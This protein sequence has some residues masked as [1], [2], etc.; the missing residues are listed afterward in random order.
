MLQAAVPPS[1]QDNSF[2]EGDFQ[3][4][5]EIYSVSQNTFDKMS[6]KEKKAI[7]RESHL[8][9]FWSGRDPKDPFKGPGGFGGSRQAL[10]FLGVDMGL[11]RTVYGEWAQVDGL[12]KLQ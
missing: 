1:E 12:F 6:D 11:M 4:Q 3:P 2:C 5:R 7:F 8:H 10:E 9:V